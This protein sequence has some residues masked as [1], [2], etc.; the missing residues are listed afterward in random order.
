[1]RTIDI[2]Q[3]HSNYDPQKEIGT[4]YTLIIYFDVGVDVSKINVD[5]EPN[6]IWERNPPSSYKSE[7]DLRAVIIRVNEI[8][9]ASKKVTVKLTQQS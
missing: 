7:G 3:E 6:N 8:L 2:V 5:V 1:M 9:G 4:S